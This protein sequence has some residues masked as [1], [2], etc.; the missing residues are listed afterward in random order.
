[1][2]MHKDLFCLSVVCHSVSLC[3]DTLIIFTGYHILGFFCVNKIFANDAWKVCYV[4]TE[5]YFRYFMDSWW[6][7]IVGF[8]FRCVYFWRCQGDHELSENYTHAKNS[9]YMVISETGHAG[10][11]SLNRGC[12]VRET[13]HPL[14]GRLTGEMTNMMDK[15]YT[16][17]LLVCWSFV[18][19]PTVPPSVCLS[20]CLMILWLYS[21]VLGRQKERMIWWWYKH[22]RSVCLSVHLSPCLTVYLMILWFI[23]TGYGKT[24]GMTNMMDEIYSGSVLEKFHFC[25]DFLFEVYEEIPQYVYSHQM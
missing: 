16:G 1:M 10:G 8:I 11:Q 14:A 9:R 25:F 13:Q 18:V 12:Y 21:Q 2:L 20:I 23:F 3:N 4:F 6:R 22:W 7:G 15:I 24:E 17:R 19:C 5:S